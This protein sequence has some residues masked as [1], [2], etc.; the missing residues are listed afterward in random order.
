MQTRDCSANPY[1]HELRISGGNLPPPVPGS[2]GNYNKRHLLFLEN[3]L[4]F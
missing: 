4:V 2:I 1:S 3:Y